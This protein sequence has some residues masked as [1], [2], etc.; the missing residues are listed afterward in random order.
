MKTIVCVTKKHSPCLSE[1]KVA[2]IKDLFCHIVNII[3]TR[4]S[5]CVVL[6]SNV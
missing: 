6:E 3:D 5:D 4:Y 1:V 2:L